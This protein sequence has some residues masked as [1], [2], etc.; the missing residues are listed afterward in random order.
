MLRAVVATAVVAVKVFAVKK[1]VKE[2]V[3][4]VGRRSER[5][6]EGSRRLKS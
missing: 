2:P 6:C 5:S 4:G 3:M 1:R